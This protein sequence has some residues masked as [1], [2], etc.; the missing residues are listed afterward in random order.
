MC[1]NSSV[2]GSS[3]LFCRGGKIIRLYCLY[4]AVFCCIFA[5]NTGPV[6]LDDGDITS[7]STN[8]D[9]FDMLFR[10]ITYDLQE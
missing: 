9:A 2:T 1:R 5:T 8:K 6:E 3:L 7:Q 4:F 10:I